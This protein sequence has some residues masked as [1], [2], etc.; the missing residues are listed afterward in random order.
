[1]RRVAAL[2]GVRG[3]AIA[4]VV[5]LHAFNWPSNGGRGVDIFFVLSGFLI[6]TL[7]MKEHASTGSI[8]FRAFYARRVRRLMPALV[9]TI[10]VYLAV[11]AITVHRVGHAALATLI[12]A[13]YTT[14]LALASG[15]AEDAGALTHTWSLSAEEQFYLL[16]PALLFLAFRARRQ[17]A[18]RVLVIAIVAVTVEQCALVA[19]GA[20]SWR[21]TFAPDTRSVGLAIGCLAA[22]CVSELDRLSRSMR[23]ATSLVVA[24][25][26]VVAG[27][28]LF[29]SR[30]EPYRLGG[31][32]VFCAAVAILLV[33]ATA[34]GSLIGRALSL[35]P[36]VWLGRISYSLYLYHLPIFIAFGVYTNGFATTEMKLIA[37]ALS[38][39]AAALSFRF[40]EQPFLRRGS[41][42]RPHPPATA[43][44]RPFALEPAVAER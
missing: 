28:G 6:T 32:T 5:G 19:W 22:L 41:R 27:V 7:L 35:I 11:S 18:I 30:V 44:S 12:A 37:I 10:V 43:D 3:I 25:S 17:T 33:R 34:G 23:T 16:W 15:H 20:P 2:D 31:L 4:A 40:L 8:G 9:V 1:V 38:V 29:T 21:L 39:L 42:S 36:L 24:L 13:S 26:V 14:N